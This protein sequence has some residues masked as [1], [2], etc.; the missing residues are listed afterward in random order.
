M[1]IYHKW[2]VAKV[3]NFAAFS[4]ISIP[5][6][7]S[8]QLSATVHAPKCYYMDCSLKRASSVDLGE[9]SKSSPGES[10]DATA[11]ASLT[12]AIRADVRVTGDQKPSE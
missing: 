5:S 3:H 2:S 9:T 1:L 12:L 11:E 6:L 4:Y 8:R 7:E 10:L